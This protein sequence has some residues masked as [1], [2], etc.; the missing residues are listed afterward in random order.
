VLGYAGFNSTV[1]PSEENYAIKMMIRT[2]FKTGLLLFAHGAA[3]HYTYAQLKN[4][5]IEYGVHTPGLKRTVT[6]PSSIV[7]ICDGAWKTIKLDKQRQKLS[8][9]VSQNEGLSKGL[10]YRCAV[11]IYLPRFLVF[12]LLA[13]CAM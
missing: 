1:I 7:S 5:N 2:E 9:Q 4:G 8:V 10:M 13:I 3:G 12:F 11:Q 6:Y